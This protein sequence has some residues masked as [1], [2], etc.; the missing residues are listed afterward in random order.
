MKTRSKKY[1][2]KPK[3]MQKPIAA[4][5]WQRVCLNLRRKIGSLSEIGREVGI[6]A[7]DIGDL[8][9]GDLLEPRF[10]AGH[11]L[12]NKHFDLLGLD[13]HLKVYEGD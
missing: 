2:V 5:N 3:I 7:H 9:R 10:T 6:S 1:N 13:E 12:L 11:L 8:S 4:I